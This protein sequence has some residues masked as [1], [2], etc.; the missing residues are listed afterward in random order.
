M[1]K[2]KVEKPQM[3]IIPREPNKMYLYVRPFKLL[4]PVPWAYKLNLKK[5]KDYGEIIKAN[6]GA[7]EEATN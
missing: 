4:A 3:I 5:L 2:V 7:R 1:A 6:L